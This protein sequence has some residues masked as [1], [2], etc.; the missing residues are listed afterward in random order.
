MKSNVLTSRSSHSMPSPNLHVLAALNPRRKL[1]WGNMEDIRVPRDMD[2]LGII[3]VVTS[4]FEITLND[5]DRTRKCK[6]LDESTCT[7]VWSVPYD[8]NR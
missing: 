7:V 5:V 8:N 4:S 6:R 2:K 3:I 1:F